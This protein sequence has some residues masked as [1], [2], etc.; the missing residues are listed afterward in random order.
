MKFYGY[1]GDSALLELSEV[2][3]KASSAELRSIASFIM[4]CAD[5]MEKYK[6]WEHEHYCDDISS[7]QCDVDFI[8]SR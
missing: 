8:V 6:S 5:E 1:E 7:T 3:I 4:K 2:T